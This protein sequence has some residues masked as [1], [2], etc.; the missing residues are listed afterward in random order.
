[1]ASDKIIKERPE[2]L[3]KYMRA[4]LKAQQST[5]ADPAI[6]AAALKAPAPEADPAIAE[7]EFRSSIP[8]ID[9]EVTKQDGMG[10]YEPTLLAATWTW[11]ARSLAIAGRQVAPDSVVDRRF[12]P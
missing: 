11:V 3:R 10:A 2:A 12:L 8:L 9:N 5:I 7:G 4:Y 1:M 6:A